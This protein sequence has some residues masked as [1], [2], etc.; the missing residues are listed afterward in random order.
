MGGRDASWWMSIISADDQSI[1][2]VTWGWL[3]SSPMGW[4][5]L[6]LL[7]IALVWLAVNAVRFGP[8]L[9]VIERRRRSPLEHLEA[10][11]A[12]LESAGAT[13]TAVQRLAAGLRRRLSRTGSVH[14]NEKQMQ[15]WLET[16]ELAMRDPKGRAAVK[17]LRRLVNERNG[18]DAQ[19]LA[20][21]QTVEEVWEQLHPPTTRERF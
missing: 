9:A 8:A 7:A 15:S 6:Q 12:G 3:R 5:L 2:G 14:T 13:E 4:A 21:A 19:V 16:L 10:L 1:W 20:A 17:R 11:G 18:G